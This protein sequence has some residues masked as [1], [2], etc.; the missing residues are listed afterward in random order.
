M[1]TLIVSEFVAL[2]G[3]MDASGGEPTRPHL[4]PHR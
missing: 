1:R 3:V 2:D 4:I